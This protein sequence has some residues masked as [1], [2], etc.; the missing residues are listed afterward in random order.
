[1][2]KLEKEGG[3]GH[4]Q[5]YFQASLSL[6]II[7]TILNGVCEQFSNPDDCVNMTKK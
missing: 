2:E 7:Y 1:M 6:E 4:I 3:A 5:A